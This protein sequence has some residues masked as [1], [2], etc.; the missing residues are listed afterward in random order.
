MENEVVKIGEEIIKSKILILFILFL[1]L[2]IT[3]F[4][5]TASEIILFLLGS[6]A[7]AISLLML[8]VHRK[9]TR[10]WIKVVGRVVDL[11]W[12]DRTLNSGQTVKFGQEVITY[13]TTTFNEHTI[14]NDFSNTKPKE[15][16][17]TIKLFYNPKNEEETLV[18][19]LFNVYSKFFFLILFGIIMIYYTL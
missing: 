13:K 16:G 2:I 8:Y 19:D 11:K 14:I 1:P 9:K 12:H 7:I 18:N 4:D 6:Y 5:Y 10:S 17:Q 3:R 15:K